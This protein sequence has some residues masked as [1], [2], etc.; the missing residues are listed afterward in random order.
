[1]SNC[2]EGTSKAERLLKRCPTIQAI[3]T[4]VV[5]SS[6]MMMTIIVGESQCDK[7]LGAKLVANGWRN[8]SISYVIFTGRLAGGN[9]WSKDS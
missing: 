1:M 2:V 3:R 9:L 5:M 8:I 6:L 7:N 4:L